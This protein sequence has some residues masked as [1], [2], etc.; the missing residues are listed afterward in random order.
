[1]KSVY[2]LWVSSFT[3]TD[4]Q[5]FLLQ[6][7]ELPETGLFETK[8]PYIERHNT[9]YR[10]PVYHAWFRGKWLVATQNYLEAV[11]VFEEAVRRQNES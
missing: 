6:Q 11:R 7:S 8:T 2:E 4:T 3:G 9:Y 10:S 1:M 5:L